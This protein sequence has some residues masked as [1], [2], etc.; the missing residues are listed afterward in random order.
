MCDQVILVK[1]ALTSL[2]SSRL[3]FVKEF[4]SRTVNFVA[5]GVAKEKIDEKNFHEEIDSWEKLEDQFLN[6]A[7]YSF[8]RIFSALWR[9]W[10]IFTKNVIFGIIY[11]AL[12]FFQFCDSFS[13]PKIR[14]IF[15]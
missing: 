5:I 10:S 3:K 6:L 4:A 15:C 11:E 14:R 2:T 12:F 9:L 8:T 7:R 1:L 13:S